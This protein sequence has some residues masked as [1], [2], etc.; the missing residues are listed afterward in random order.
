[1]L[2]ENLADAAEQLTAAPRSEQSELLDRIEKLTAL[3]RYGFRMLG[4]EP[5]A[6]LPAFK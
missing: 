6:R 4:E 3:I 2:K 5:P 1:L